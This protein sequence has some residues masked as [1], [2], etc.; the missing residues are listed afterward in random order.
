MAS[1]DSAESAVTDNV[2]ISRLLEFERVLALAGARGF[3]FK[4]GDLKD[5]MFPVSKASSPPGDNGSWRQP[6]AAAA[7]TKAP[8]KHRAAKREPLSPGSACSG[9]SSTGSG[10]SFRG[11]SLRIS[12]SLVPHAS[13]VRRGARL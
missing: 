9:A 1:I 6:V 8:K 11:R 10:R 3:Y 12:T 2:T 13:V 7:A 4:S 5:N